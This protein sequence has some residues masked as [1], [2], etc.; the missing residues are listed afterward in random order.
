[1]QQTNQTNVTG[2]DQATDRNLGQFSDNQAVIFNSTDAAGVRDTAATVIRRLTEDECDEHDVGPMYLIRLA[3]GSEH[4][5]FADEL[6]PQDRNLLTSRELAEQYPVKGSMPQ[7][8]VQK[9]YQ[10][11]ETEVE[12]L[13]RQQVIVASDLHDLDRG[14]RGAVANL[15]FIKCDVS[16]REALLHDEHHQ[17]RSCAEIAANE[18][19]QAKAKE[20]S[21]SLGI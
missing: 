6:L 12:R 19:S 4:H 13:S 16:A 1:M 5:A 17:V 10:L 20:N 9:L 18:L 21:P 15:L 7:Q 2:V 11:R 8:V 14:A 3:D